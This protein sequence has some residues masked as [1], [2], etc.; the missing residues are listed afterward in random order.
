MDQMMEALEQLTRGIDERVGES[1]SGNA[2]TTILVVDDGPI[3]R[4]ALAQLLRIGGHRILLAND[5]AEAL[6]IV[7]AENPDVVV[8]DI[9]MPTMDGYEFAR[10]LRADPSIARTPLIFLTAG[11]ELEEARTL[12]NSCGVFYVL[13]KAA[14]PAELLGAIAAVLA[15]AGLPEPAVS[16]ESFDRAHR[17]LLTDTLAKKVEE[18]EVALA[19]S[20]KKELQLLQTVKETVKAEQALEQSNKDLL[21][22]NQ[23]IQSFYHTVSHELKTPLTSAREFVSI[24][25]EGL[26]GPLN[27]TQ[28]EYLGIAR[29]SCNRLRICINDLMDATRLETGKLTLKMKLGS[30]AGLM[31]Q[32]VTILGPVAVR[33][34]INLTQEVQPN[35]PDFLFDENRLM[36]VL[37]NLVNN[38]LKFTSA[39]GRVTVT[40]GDAPNHPGHIQICVKDTG[41]GIPRAEADRIFERLYQIQDS[42]GMTSPG[43]GL[44]L[45]IS[46]EL[47]RSHGGDIWVESEPGQGST[48]CFV[49]PK[50]Q[51]SELIHVLVV[52]DE[53]RMLEL[54][55][56]GLSREGFQVTTAENGV[57]ALEKMKQAMPDIV[58][59]DLEMPEMDGAQMLK[60][61]RHNWGLLP[62]IILTGFPDKEHMRRAMDFSPFTVLAKPCSM[63]QL[64]KTIRSLLP[65]KMAADE[66]WPAGSVRS[67]ADQSA[68]HLD[69]A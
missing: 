10:R 45:Y 41:C 1:R 38:A 5:G 19:E 17:R 40:A 33:K 43:V 20:R 56:R 60:E 32:L 37:V 62:V 4:M 16:E 15:E 6:T 46:R 65:R 51:P 25:M 3:R 9:L 67:G 39:N 57:V 48:F 36:Q 52:D 66:N 2:G 42:D 12:A 18:L 53:T 59:T 50:D 30:I 13:N 8:T 11:Y 31:G 26:A 22:K 58:I 34:Q 7:R 68:N 29:E 64:C 69:L 55:S 61:I 14:Q 54:M 23:E 21:Q 24:V 47:V 63:N 35:L 28:L 49:I 44:G 27:E